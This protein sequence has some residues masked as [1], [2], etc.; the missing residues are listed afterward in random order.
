MPTMKVYET[1]QQQNVDSVGGGERN[2]GPDM[3]IF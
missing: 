3:N 1:L 2:A